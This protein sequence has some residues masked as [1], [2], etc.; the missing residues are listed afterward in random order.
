MHGGRIHR[1]ADLVQFGFLRRLGDRSGGTG[2]AEA[3]ERGDPDPDLPT[4]PLGGMTG[5]FERRGTP[6][7]VRALN[8]ADVL[9]QV[10]PALHGLAML[11]G[12]L[13]VGLGRAAPGGLSAF[14]L[15]VLLGLCAWATRDAVTRNAH[16]PAGPAFTTRGLVFVLMLPLV[17]D[18]ARLGF[19]HWFWTGGA[20][21]LYPLAMRSARA[22]PFAVLCALY[23]GTFACLF[24]PELSTAEL[25]LR[26]GIFLVIA[27][28]ARHFGRV[29]DHQARAFTGLQV[30]EQRALAI[31]INT[32]VMMV[33][34]DRWLIPFQFNHAVRRV[35]GYE[36]AA[37][38]AAWGRGLLHP[39]DRRKFIGE[40][41]AL[42]RVPGGS[43]V[44]TVR[45]RHE[46]G[47][48]V[49]LEL[50]ATNLLDNPAVRGIYASAT[51]VTG[52]VVAEDKLRYQA[53]HDPL[54]ALY[55]RG[56]FTEQLAQAM[57]QARV[58][59]APLS[60]FFC[61]LDFFKGINDQYGH[62]AGDRFLRVMA[63]R[64]AEHAKGAGRVLSRFGGDEFV[65]LAPVGEPVQVQALAESLRTTLSM[66][67][68]MNNLVLQI[69]ASI[70]VASLS[71][72]H[73]GPEK[74]IRDA[75]AAM[76][77]AKE[78]GRNR[79][80]LFDEELRL[81]ALRRADLARMM[82]GGLQRREFSLVYQPKVALATGQLMG[83]EVL[84]RWHSPGFGVID[85]A[86]FIPI[87]EDSGMIVPIGLWALSEACSQLALWQSRYARARALVLAVNVSMRQLLHESF[88]AEAL[89]IIDEAGS[90]PGTIELE[91]T[92][93]A[94]MVNPDQTIAMLTS[95]KNS[96]LR[97]AI[98]DFGTGYS[99]LAWLRRL[100]VDAIKIDQAFV[101]NM[102][103]HED[104]LE[105]VKLMIALS[106]TLGLA[107][108]GE[109]VETREDA[110]ALLALG[111][112]LGQGFYFHQPLAAGEAEQLIKTDPHYLIR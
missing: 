66:P 76:Y 17:F 111:C 29:I 109:G 51:D 23:S 91:I 14:S 96:G 98:D 71:P 67:V 95:L 25:V 47:Y 60:L 15:L 103:D 92:E 26:T 75:D 64:L 45:V 34:V 80:A 50:R 69:E 108:V 56:Y 86:E 59:G 94:A 16:T 4:S 35:L 13:F 31:A 68:R 28:L 84:I 1:D 22:A 62:E 93:T 27:A 37:F 19:W 33:V 58:K 46:R 42:L 112:Q 24:D 102:R 73:D 44:F 83:F 49:W 12:L 65:L 6:R 8:A 20:M 41:R 97:L 88:V 81:A 72:E 9:H 18:P 30:G 7:L 105:I 2:G 53:S 55:N 11:Q 106:Q 10:E 57:G 38:R 87:A 107:S 101:V 32:D 63:E 77:Q 99:S 89:R 61:D 21:I 110:Q 82:R 78:R 54:T 79:I 39:E 40:W 100:P 52:R 74:L 85:P 104:D 43:R 5:N 90:A 48:W 3:A 70:G 36:D